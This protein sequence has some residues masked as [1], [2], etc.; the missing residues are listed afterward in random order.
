MLI[1]IKWTT[2]TH[3]LGDCASHQSQKLR[4]ELESGLLVLSFIGIYLRN[5]IIFKNQIPEPN[6]DP[7]TQEV[8]RDCPRA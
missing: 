1:I 2:H 8:A 7:R 6:S 3:I 5:L 4:A